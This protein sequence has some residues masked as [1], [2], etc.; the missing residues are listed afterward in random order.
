MVRNKG[1]STRY[2]KAI[3]DFSDGMRIISCD[4]GFA[5]IFGYSQEEVTGG[6]VAVSD[7]MSPDEIGEVRTD[8]FFLSVGYIDHLHLSGAV[9]VIVEIPVL[10]DLAMV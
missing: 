10:Q 6:R 7:I 1:K 2:V 9:V 5:R 4:N 3:V 8:G